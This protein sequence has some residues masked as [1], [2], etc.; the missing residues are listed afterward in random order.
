[1]TTEG[2]TVGVSALGIVLV[3]TT[4]HLGL[5]QIVTFSI[6]TVIGL[7]TIVYLSV[8]IFKTFKQRLP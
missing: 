4:S 6:Q 3:E 8:K 1:M 2:K 5:E 7:L